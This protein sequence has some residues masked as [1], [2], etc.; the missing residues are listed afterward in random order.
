MIESHRQPNECKYKAFCERM[1]LGCQFK[2]ALEGVREQ[3]DPEHLE[4]LL[5]NTRF[6]AVCP[7]SREIITELSEIIDSRGL[8]IMTIKRPRVFHGGPRT[9]IEQTVYILDEKTL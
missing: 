9:A 8:K 4:S 6:K 1:D 7:N 2:S 5:N 3:P